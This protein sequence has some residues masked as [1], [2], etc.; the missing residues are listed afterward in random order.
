M[1]IGCLVQL[2]IPTLRISIE[3]GA[4]LDVPT[5]NVSSKTS[6]CPL[7]FQILALK[8]FTNSNCKLRYDC[9]AQGQ[10]PQSPF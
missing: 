9:Q 10:T 4:I 7:W 8:C 1:N 6:P 2:I 3:L 5:L